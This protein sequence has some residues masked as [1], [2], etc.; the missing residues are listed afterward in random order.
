MELCQVPDKAQEANISRLMEQHGD[1]LLR[2]CY[3][4][5]GDVQLAEDAVQET[6]VKAY[7]KYHTFRADCSEMS[8]LCAIAVNCCRD[9][10]RSTWFRHESGRS[11]EEL[12]ETG[13]E[14]KD[15]DDTLLNEVM[16]LPGKYREVILLHYF[17]G[18]SLREISQTLSVNES[19]L[20]SRLK[21][22]R[23]KLRSKLEG[24][25]FNEE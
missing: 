19:T 13:V 25:Y 4:N 11:I 21:R 8:W 22:A 15:Y 20:S 10:R 5:L 24:W 9:I 14:W 2:F 3:L 18:I 12:P 16:N 1:G 17:Q 6:F 7:Q 23:K